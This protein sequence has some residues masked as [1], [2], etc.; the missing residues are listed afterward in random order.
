GASTA[1]DQ[2]DVASRT[3]GAGSFLQGRTSHEV[4][5]VEFDEPTE[6]GGESGQFRGEFLGVL[7]HEGFQAR[8]D[9][10]RETSG[11]KAA[12]ASTRGVSRAARPAGRRPLRLPSAVSASQIAGALSAGLMNISK[13]SSPV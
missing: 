1:R 4:A 2:T 12:S 7:K 3:G 11:E 5:F 9:A 13:P 8:G 6:P 10:G